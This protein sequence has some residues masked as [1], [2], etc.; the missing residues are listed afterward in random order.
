MIRIR[1]PPKEVE[2]LEHVLRSSDDPGPRTRA[3]IVLM[4]HRGRPH[5]QIACD[6]ATA[7]SSAQRRPDAYTE[8][9]VGALRPRKPGRPRPELAP[10]L[11]R[12]VLEG[13]Q[14]RGPD[15]A[16]S[17]DA[18]LAE[19]LFR[20]RGIRVGKSAMQAFCREHDIRPY[21]PTYRP[22]RGDPERQAEARAELA[23]L[24]G[25]R[26]RATWPC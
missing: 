21:R 13:P 6:T 12:W 3:R 17:T 20:T 23:E 26:R 2:R 25:G 24:K 15:R 7:R 19:H 22:L 1:P 4:A 11:C 16:S 8:R 9:G 14:A 5:G 10:V 18:E